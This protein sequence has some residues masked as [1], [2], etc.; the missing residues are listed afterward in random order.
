MP[1]QFV[2]PASED[3]HNYQWINPLLDNNSWTGDRQGVSPGIIYYNFSNDVETGYREAAISALHAWSNITN[4]TFTQDDNA[5]DQRIV[6]SRSDSNSYLGITGHTYNQETFLIEGSEVFISNNYF[7]IGSDLSQGTSGFVVLLHEIGHALGLDHP[8]EESNYAP[9]YESAFQNIDYS[10]MNYTY[11]SGNITSAYGNPITPQFT[12]IAAIHYLYGA[13]NSYNAGDTVYEF[14]GSEVMTL[15]DGGGTDLIDASGQSDAVYIN[16]NEADGDAYSVI[17]DTAFWIAYGA[18]I[19]NATGGAGYDIILGNALANEIRGLGGSDMIFANDGDDTVNGN[20]DADH[21]LG[22]NDNDL[23]RGGRDNDYI[24]GNQGSD[25]INGNLGDDSLRGGQDADILHGGQGNDRITGDNGND[26]I[27]GD[28]GDDIL[29]GDNDRDLF[30]FNALNSGNDEIWD[31]VSG[32]DQIQ[33]LNSPF[34]YASDALAAFSNSVLD[35]GNG[36][37]I[38]LTGVSSLVESDFVI[39]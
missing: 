9:A 10:I 26:T 28:L 20:M 3:N 17:G 37:S 16:L 21:I 30:V 23:L 11:L 19:E 29:F 39:G 31:F 25:F 7:P 12:D 4:I 36:N 1:A 22:G 5:T 2:I 33:L 32:V 34:A 14:S 27:Y 35:L 13:N 18:N 8:N 38:T 24:N 15:W 6:F